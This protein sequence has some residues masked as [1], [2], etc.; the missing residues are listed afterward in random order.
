MKIPYKHIVKHISE[1]PD[2]EELSSKLF[3]LGHEHEILNEIFDIE[4]TPNRG[5]CLSL[6]GLLNDLAA[7][8][9]IESNM[10]IYDGPLDELK[11][12]FEN[13][14]HKI[15]PKISF[16]KIEIEDN[17]KT[18]H[19]EL[20]SYYEDLDNKPINFFTDVSNFLAYETGQPT[21]A[22]E[23]SIFESKISLKEITD[24]YEFKTLLN[25]QITLTDKNTVFCL[26]DEVINLAGI[27]GGKNS[28]CKT[29]TRA[30]VI[31]C[32]YFSP[33][34]IIGKTVKYDI[35][36]EA[37]YKFERGVDALQQEYVLRRFINIVQEHATVKNVQFCSYDFLEI[38]KIRIKKDMNLVN[39]VLGTNIDDFEFENIFTKLGFNFDGE[40][41]EVPS[42]RSD[43]R[44]QNDLAEEV[45][46]VI[47][48]DNIQS[49]NLILPKKK[50]DHFGSIESNLKGFLVDNGFFEVI[51]FP[52]CID[53]NKESIEVDNSLDSNKKFLRTDMKISLLN[54]L[55]Y[56]ER[57]QKDSIKLFEISDIYTK[58]N[59]KFVKK[60]KVAL[61]ASG[62][63]A[64]N[65]RDFSKKISK[66]VL[67]TIFIDLIPKRLLNFET[68][69]RENL[70]SKSKD[71]IFFLEINFDDVSKNILEYS[72]KS[73]PP[74]DYIEYH[75]I[76][77]L[78]S[79]N[80]DI[81]FSIRDPED[82]YKLEKILKEYQNDILKEKFVF[83]FFYNEKKG[84][85]KLGFRFIFQ[86]N[87]K[88]LTESEIS[89]I[90]N[91]IIKEVLTLKSVNIPGL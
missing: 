46:R 20:K 15:C 80:R 5:D 7:F 21:H 63:L 42:S 37:A 68:I 30:A 14:C 39:K 18:Y 60:K 10:E 23:A 73:N 61:I 69:S 27:M 25:D 43:V 13:E 56:N 4:F 35:N 78:P 51:N 81:S 86:S 53:K 84:E 9:S 41:I 58:E 64:R 90:L 49:K 65:Y 85:I 76:S 36:S 29:D 38:P 70:D 87:E 33:E 72:P 91:D 83:D 12:N 52:F 17:I 79:S 3:Q 2:L 1:K 67:E 32:A 8:Y 31:E 28:S 40:Y 50:K 6:K 66:E 34:A 16:L 71:K 19:S 77:E 48:Y 26:E 44:T 75:P 54:N 47:G 82:L 24:P 57:R 62:R 45:A 11:I 89:I 74:K 88:T 59:N 22:Y 55:L